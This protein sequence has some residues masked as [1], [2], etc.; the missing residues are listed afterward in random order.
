MSI[1]KRAI[2]EIVKNI[3]NSKLE[4]EFANEKI[5]HKTRLLKK[6]LITKQEFDR[7]TS[8]EYLSSLYNKMTTLPVEMCHS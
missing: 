8:K 1:D 3:T 5:A 4:E 2:K 6:G 7:C